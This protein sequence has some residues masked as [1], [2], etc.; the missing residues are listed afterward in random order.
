M[1]NSELPA[2]CPAPLAAASSSRAKAPLSNFASLAEQVGAMAQR[3]RLENADH[4]SAKLLFV[5]LGGREQSV[6]LCVRDTES[7]EVVEV[8]SVADAAIDDKKTIA[9]LAANGKPGLAG[10]VTI[11]VEGGTHLFA[12]AANLMETLD[13]DE[14]ARM[15]NAAARLA[16]DWE[17]R[18]SQGGDQW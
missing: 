17:A 9:A 10:F 1:S 15:V 7:G 3:L 2:W 11:D 14:L 8:L 13:D 12:R 5:H 18:Q 6:A 16:D 4:G